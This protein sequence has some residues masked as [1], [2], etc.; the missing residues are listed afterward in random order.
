MNCPVTNRYAEK[1]A[2][3]FE[4]SM[5]TK[6]SMESSISCDF[7]T[8]EKVRNYLI[9]KGFKVLLFNELKKLSIAIWK[10]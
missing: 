4:N 9:E 2:F 3:E 1:L 10:K 7:K 6:D 8:A 5:K